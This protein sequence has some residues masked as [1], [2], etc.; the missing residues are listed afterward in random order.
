MQN[1]RGREVHTDALWLAKRTLEG[2]RSQRMY[3]E[4]LQEDID[5]KY[6]T[7]TNMVV[8]YGEH[9]GHSSEIKMNP[10]ARLAGNEDFQDKRKELSRAKRILTRAERAVYQLAKIE[11]IIITR[12][13]IEAKPVPW[14]EIALEVGYEVRNC[15]KLHA[16]AIRSIAVYLCGL[17]K[18]LKR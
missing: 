2:L 4:N 6:E 18:T 12:R 5:D 1:K 16:K 17:E 8:V 13:Y 15:H 9:I 7:A 3:V 10:G 14:A 11:Q